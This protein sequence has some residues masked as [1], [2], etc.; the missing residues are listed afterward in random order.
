MYTATARTALPTTIIGSLPRPSWYT[1]NLGAR[2]F[3]EALVDRLY[4]EQ[5]LDACSA[6]LRDQETAGLDIVT[7]G[8][9][10]FDADVAGHNWFSY[11]PLHMDGFAGS[12][13]YAAQGGLAGIPHKPGHI[14]HDVLETRVMP[15]LVGPVGRGRLR[16]AAIWKAAQRLTTRPVKFGTITA[17]LIAMSV[18]DLYYRD[19]RKSIL[20]ISDA[21]N[22][23]LHELADAGCKVI[24][25]EEPQI[26]LLAAKGLSDK[27]LNADFMVEVFNNTVRG[28]RAKSEVWCHTCWGN[29]A[30]QRLFVSQPSYA[31]ALDALARVDAD[32]L[33]FET[34]S[35]GGTDF[36][37]IGRRIR[38]QKV[39]I[40]VVDHHSLQV[41]TPDQV[42][43]LVRQALEHMPKERLVL[44]S[45]C[46]M[47]REGMSRRHAYYKMVSIVRGANLVRRELGLPEAP[48]LAADERFSMVA[49]A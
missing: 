17:E 25:L 36:A 26:H 5:Y 12:R 41:E 39:C 11:A 27:V 24:Q 40:G 1:R 14:L 32:V 23:E 38:D 4:R 7:D 37:A 47:G 15:D 16:Y 44:G 34:C 18:R 31:P 42:A 6:Y 22:E 19:L 29:P 30:A 46:G 2:D 8:D 10:R 49:Q 33:T 28:L 21:L 20:A 13:P 9:C 48:C 35:S 43:A 45:D 3:R